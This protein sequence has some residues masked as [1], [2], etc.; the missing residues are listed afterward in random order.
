MRSAL[1]AVIFL[2][3]LIHV[4]GFVGPLELVPAAPFQTVLFGRAVPNASPAA[5]AMGVVWLL[6][7]LLFSVASVAIF[8][9]ASWWFPF[10]TLAL[11]MSLLLCL[12][13][14]PVAKVGAAVDAGLLL[15]CLLMERAQLWS[16]LTAL[17]RTLPF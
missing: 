7:A 11:L 2:H 14:W 17:L 1:S 13:A 3:G 4:V 6:M 10:T 16:D 15:V 9:H 12:V 8:A 5:R